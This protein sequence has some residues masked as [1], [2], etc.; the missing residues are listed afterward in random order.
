MANCPVGT[1]NYAVVAYYNGVET[2]RATGSFRIATDIQAMT[3]LTVDVYQN[4]EMDQIKFR[5]YALDESVVQLTW[6][7]GQPAGIAGSGAANN[8]YIIG[9]TPTA[10]EGVY[11]FKIT[12]SGADTTFEGSIHVKKLDYGQNPVLYLYK[13]TGADEKD[14]VYTHL[15]S[16]S[17]N[18][19]SRKACRFR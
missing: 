19:I 16:K 17:W 6:P 3:E 13:N 4:E 12:A 5:Y 18:V 8:T 7:N 9:G 2:S 10:A 11:K 14:G 1:Y 15:K